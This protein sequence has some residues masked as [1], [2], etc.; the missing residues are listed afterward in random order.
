MLSETTGKSGS[1]TISYLLTG[2][3]TEH[4][5]PRVAPLTGMSS[6]GP[7]LGLLFSYAAFVLFIGPRYMKN[8]KPYSL[9]SVLLAYNLT[10]SLL[11]AFFFYRVIFVDYNYGMD[12]FNVVFPSFEDTSPAVMSKIHLGHMYLFSKLVDLLDTI[13]FVLRKKQSQ[14]TPL[15]FFHHFSGKFWY[16][17]VW[18]ECF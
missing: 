3:W 18:K 17:C 12:M 15:H 13:F 5:D 9:K 11:N 14:V 7:L 1:G 2:Y 6:I 4:G 16:T 10:M 8:R